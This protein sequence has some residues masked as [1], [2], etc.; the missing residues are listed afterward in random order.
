MITINKDDKFRVLLTEVLPYEVP[1][2]LSNNCFYKLCFSGLITYQSGALIINGQGISLSDNLIPLDYFIGKDDNS[3]RKLSIMHP[4]AQLKVVDFYEQYGDIIPYYCQCSEATLRAPFAIAKTIRNTDDA[5]EEKELIEEEGELSPKDEDPPCRTFLDTYCSSYYTYKKIDFFYKFFESYEFHRLEKRYTKCLQ[6]DVAK[7]FD[8]IYT[9]SIC[10][11]IKG[12]ATAKLMAGKLESFEGNFDYLMQTTNYRETHGILIGPELSRIFAE[13][14]FQK[15]DNDLIATLSQ[16]SVRWSNKKDYEFRRY[17]DDYIIFFNDENCVRDIIACLEKCLIEYKMHLNESKTSYSMRPFISEISMCKMELR[18]LIKSYFDSKYDEEGE[19]QNINRPSSVANRIIIRIKAI[20]KKFSS[21]SYKSI[22]GFLLNDFTRGIDRFLKKAAEYETDE[23]C[24]VNNLLIDL[25]IIFFVH[26]MDI[27]VRPTDLLTRVILGI[28]RSPLL[29][30]G[31][32]KAPIQRKIF[33]SCRDIFTILNVQKKKCNVE[34]CNVLLMLSALEEDFQFTEPFLIKH[35]EMDE[36]KPIDY[37]LWGTL[38]LYIRD[39]PKYSS[40]R[41]V[42][43]K[44]LIR[45]FE[46]G[47][48]ILNSTELFML[49]LDSLACPYLPKET[50]RKIIRI[51]EARS[52]LGLSQANQDKFIASCSRHN[53]FLDWKNEDWLFEMAKRKMYIF[54]Y[55]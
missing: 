4:L 48:D 22:S 12:K 16:N 32:C 38:M 3:F 54:P 28:L 1:I 49:L 25:D 15:I 14:I 53:F 9:H 5:E 18:D 21:I 46:T 30:E 47:K 11:A 31:K 37:F 43:E 26:S 7:C 23:R 40:F 35:C 27:R 19:P 50:K 10:W 24:L 8:S 33:D 52:T 20:V 34:I 41:M 13:I 55:E 51:V 42:L 45:S 36:E 29:Q 44:C 6:V 17:V 39:S 2:W